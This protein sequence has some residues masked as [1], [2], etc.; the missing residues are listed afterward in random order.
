MGYKRQPRVENGQELWQCLRCE[1]WFSRDE[2]YKE[3]RSSIG[4]KSECKKCH[5]KTSMETRDASR[6][7]SK[8]REWMNDSG[9]SR[10]PEVLE[11]NRMRS[12]RRT[13][14]LASKCRD[15]LNDA[16]RHDVLVRPSVCPICGKEGRVEGHHDSYYRPLE[17][18]WMCPLC[19]AEYHRGL[20]ILVHKEGT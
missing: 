15:I 1:Q 9:Y 16:V 4:I 12:R 8:N 13:R 3:L 7:R 14:S 6:H 17:V 10:R 5:I 20:E 11:R 2:F 18:R 19:H